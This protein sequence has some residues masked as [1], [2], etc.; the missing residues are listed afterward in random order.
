MSDWQDRRDIAQAA[1]DE[2]RLEDVNRINDFVTFDTTPEGIE[3]YHPNGR[4]FIYW[5]DV[6]AVMEALARAVR[7]YDDLP[8][9]MEEKASEE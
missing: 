3:L 2:Q 7:L 6:P 5:G 4:D 1:R 8:A 9:R